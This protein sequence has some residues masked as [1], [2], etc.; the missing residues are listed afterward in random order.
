MLQIPISILFGYFIDWSMILLG[1]VNPSFYLMKIIYLLIG[2]LI[3]GFGV[4]TEVLANVAMLPGESFVRAIVMT[5]HTEFGVTKICFDV[6]MTVIAGVLSFVFAGKLDGVREGTVI[7]ALLVG[8]IA[9]LFGRFL[10]FVEPMLFPDSDTNTDS[11]TDTDS[12]DTPIVIAIAREYGSGGHDL[13]EA[14][15]TSW[16]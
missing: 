8:F 6:S 5:W 1:F 4:Y 12:T 11:D 16:I 15:A 2:C 14:L 13:G 7:A 3:L 9:R 10:S